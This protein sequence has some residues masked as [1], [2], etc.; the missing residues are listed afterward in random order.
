MGIYLIIDEVHTGVA[1]TGKFW[2]HEW[3]DLESPPDLVTFSKKFQASGFFYSDELK[4]TIPFRHFNT[5]MGDPVRTLIAAEQ[6]D[7]IA[8]DNLI[9]NAN[10]SGAYFKSQLE[11]IACQ[12]PEMM[13]NVRGRGLCLAYDIR[14]L[15][16]R[17]KMIHQLKLNGV[18]SPVCG[19]STIRARP[20]LYW[21]PAHTDVYISILEKTIKQCT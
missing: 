16:T 3:W 6:N 13:A 17:T 19:V 4:Q 10:T 21:T 15:E 2:A 14:D 18:N 8:R 7:I 9:E 20:C 5:W 1:A 11:E 12:Y